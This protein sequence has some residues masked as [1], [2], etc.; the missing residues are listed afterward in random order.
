MW[1]LLVGLCGL[2]CSVWTLISAIIVFGPA[3]RKKKRHP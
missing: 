2:F 3:L 1:D